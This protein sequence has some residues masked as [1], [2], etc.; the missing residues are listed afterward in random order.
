M[1]VTY[2]KLTLVIASLGF[3]N[4]NAQE[5]R[6]KIKEYGLGLS[7]LNNFSLQYRWG[8]ESKIKRV[9]INMGGSTSFGKGKGS[10]ARQEQN[11]SYN[12]TN[13]STNT[14]PINLNVGVGYSILKLKPLNDKFGL[15]FG[16]NFSMNYSNIKLESVTTETTTNL[17]ISSTSPA[18]IN[19]KATNNTQSVVP[20][21]GLGLGF[22]YI[23]NSSFRVYAEIGPGVYYNYNTTSEKREVTS[24]ANPTY[25]YSSRNTF[26]NNTFGFTGISNSGALLSFIYRIGG[27]A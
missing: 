12:S 27:K 13:N 8:N 25:S 2:L 9:S 4:I 3:A 7:N 20:T 6:T 19:T 1:K 26:Y 11:S 18:L 22:Y 15:M 5:T 16:Y 17:N 21:L 23:I 10:Y 24:D 14:S